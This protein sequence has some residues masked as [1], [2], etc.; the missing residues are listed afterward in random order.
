MQ[1][2]SADRLQECAQQVALCVLLAV[3]RPSSL[4]LSWH[5]T[6]GC[7][8]VSSGSGHNLPGAHSLCS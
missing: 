5:F 2:L 1:C 6:C 4:F 3:H 8:I 7:K